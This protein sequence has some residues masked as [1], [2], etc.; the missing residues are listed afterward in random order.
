[1]RKRL[2]PMMLNCYSEYFRK[3]AYCSDEFMANHLLR[4]FCPYKFGVPDYCKNRYKV[5]KETSDLV[6]PTE[7]DKSN[8]LAIESLTMTPNTSRHE[9]VIPK[10]E[11]IIPVNPAVRTKNLGSLDS[12]LGDKKE[13]KLSFEELDCVDFRVDVYDVLKPNPHSSLFRIEIGPYTLVWTNKNGIL[14]TL[15]T[16]ILWM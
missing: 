12:F 2:V 11:P 10:A 3:C 6:K 14:L 4:R 1:M 15:T 13:R 5:L 16:E 8:F 9:P 7:S